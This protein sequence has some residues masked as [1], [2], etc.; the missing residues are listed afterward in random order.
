MLKIASVC[1]VL[2]LTVD[3]AIFKREVSTNPNLLTNLQT[4]MDQLRNCVDQSLA[5]VVGNVNEQQL[6]PILNVV[7]DTLNKVSKAFE[8]LTA[9]ASV[10]ANSSK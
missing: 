8:D 7:G 2:L 10:P 6:K 3:G 5:A 9:P 1:C 4:N